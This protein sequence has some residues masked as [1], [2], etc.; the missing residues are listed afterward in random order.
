M[1][2]RAP[3][4]SATVFVNVSKESAKDSLKRSPPL[5]D[6]LR[7]LNDAKRAL[8]CEFRSCSPYGFGFGL[9]CGLGCC[10]LGCGLLEGGFSTLSCSFL[11]S[12]NI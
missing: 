8:I 7:D 3:W 10:G 6:E 11:L 2:Y 1:L 5:I 12:V 9:G 4:A